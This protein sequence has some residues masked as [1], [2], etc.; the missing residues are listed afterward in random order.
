VGGGAAGDGKLE[1]RFE[2]AGGGA[3][4]RTMKGGIAHS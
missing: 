3:K 1:Q 4:E 2:S